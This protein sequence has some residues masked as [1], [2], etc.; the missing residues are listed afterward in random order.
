MYF[1]IILFLLA[2]ILPLSAQQKTR[3]QDLAPAVKDSIRNGITSSSNVAK[4]RNITDFGAILSDALSDVTAFNSAMTWSSDSNGVVLITGTGQVT[5]D[6]TII[7]KDNVTFVGNKSTTIIRKSTYTSHMFGLTANTSNVVFDGLK[8]NNKSS[9]TGY[10]IDDGAS[11]YNLSN[12]RMINCEFDSLDLGIN[13][14]G[15]SNENPVVEDCK[16][17]SD[18]YQSIFVFNNVSNGHFEN[19]K[20]HGTTMK[21]EGTLSNITF[22]KSS[23]D[24]VDQSNLFFRPGIG[25]SVYDIHATFNTFKNCGW[26]TK[27]KGAI[28]MGEINNGDSTEYMKRVH[29]TGNTVEGHYG[30]GI[31]VGGGASVGPN[32]RVQDVEIIGN[33]IRGFTDADSGH[34]GRNSIGLLISSTVRNAIVS[35]NQVYDEGANGIFNSGKDIVIF[36]NKVRNVGLD[37]T[38][39]DHRQTGGIYIAAGSERVTVEE[40]EVTNCGSSQNATVSDDY[41]AG[42]VISRGIGSVDSVDIIGNR[43]TDT[44][45]TRYTFYGIAIA[46]KAATNQFPANLNIRDNNCKGVDSMAVTAPASKGDASEAGTWTIQDNFLDSTYVTITANSTTLEHYNTGTTY[47]GDSTGLGWT[48]VLHIKAPG[49]LVNE[50]FK[51]SGLDTVEVDTQYTFKYSVNVLDYEY[52]PGGPVQIRIYDGLN[53]EYADTLPTGTFYTALP[54]YGSELILNGSFDSDV[55]SWTD[56][57]STPTLEWVASGGGFAGALHVI[58]DGTNDGA[59]QVIALTAGTEY[60]LKA[61]INRVSGTIRGLMYTDQ[62]EPKMFDATTIQVVDTIFTCATTDASTIFWMFSPSA[63]ASEFYADD[64]SVRAITSYDT[65]YSLYTID[66]TFTASQTLDDPIISFYR[67]SVNGYEVIVDNFFLISQPTEEDPYGDTLNVNGAFNTNINNWVLYSAA[68][69][70]NLEWLSTDKLISIKLPE[71]FKDY[72][73]TF[74]KETDGM[75][76]I[77]PLLAEQIIGESTGIPYQMGEIG[78]TVSFISK[79]TGK[80]HAD[81]QSYYTKARFIIDDPISAATAPTD[82]QILRYNSTLDS[83]FWETDVDSLNNLSAENWKV[84][85]SDGSGVVT[86]LTLG[87]NGTVFKSNGATAAPT[88][89]SDATGGGGGTDYA[90]SLTHDGRQVPGDSIPTDAEIAALLVD[91]LLK[92]AV[93]DSIIQVATDSGYGAGATGSSYLV[94]SNDGTLSAERSLVAGEAIDFTD[95]GA[96]TTFTIAAEEATTSNKGVVQPSSNNFAVASG[97]LTIKTD[98]INDPSQVAPDVIGASEIATGAVGASELAVSG[99]VAGTYE[100]ATI[101]VDEDGRITS[102]STA[103][104]IKRNFWFGVKDT[105]IVGA[106]PAQKMAENVTIEEIDIYCDAGT[107]TM[108]FEWRAEATPNNVGTDVMN[109]NLTGT[110]TGAETSSFNDP[111]GAQNQ[112]LYGEI[113]SRTGSP[114]LVVA[115]VRYTVD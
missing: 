30:V 95:G 18:D 57:G 73:Y 102:I 63:G 7:F 39:T 45:A 80:W 93:R 108:K 31:G 41:A 35:L 8:F 4:Q 104:R 94:V 96:N 44:R 110:T 98:G 103:N 82:N 65:V 74:V 19:N 68:P 114:T 72:T 49:D 50:G 33:Y 42:I 83:I 11:N 32:V 81:K 22:T 27:S 91:Y 23:F 86:A 71:A 92:A 70:N 64:I 48:G 13:L 58:G 9:A 53:I 17:N 3:W 52:I 62:Y 77:Y 79:K 16:F 67:N 61:K 2:F 84:W 29:I 111:T 51:Q 115:T 88:W 66:T 5:I 56:N 24:S 78:A 90:D 97:V 89:Q 105:V 6:D 46:P 106:L 34:T 54:N 87:A 75:F 37:S 99:V 76:R 107:V 20:F 101:V 60:H 43:I 109:A 69:V 55:A 28:V 113:V 59:R 1:K 40:N 15:A 25:D 47:I 26:S 21:F 14:G 85:Y 10:V 38:K 112:R 100:R 36:K 12:F